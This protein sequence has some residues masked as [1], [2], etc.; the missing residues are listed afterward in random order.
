M[1]LG[2]STYLQIPLMAESDNQ[3]YLLHNDA[4]QA[5]DDSLNRIL[6]LDFS[7]SDV[8]LAESQ[9]TRYG[10]FRGVSHT[11]PRVLTIPTTVGVSPAITT[12]RFF[13]FQNAG[14]DS[15][16]LTHGSGNVVS[17]PAGTVTLVICDGTDVISVA[18]ASGFDMG[19][20]DE[21]SADF[22]SN[23]A[24][25]NFVGKN[26][27]ATLSGL[28][29]DI[30]VTMPEVEDGGVSVQT[31]T[32][33][34]N[35][36]GA[37]VT[38]VPNGDGVDITIPGATSGVDVEDEGVGTVTAAT[39]LDFIGA[40]VSVADVGGD[41]HVTISAPAAQ[42]EGVGVQSDP[43]FI[44]F[45]GAGVS[46]AVNGSGVD[47]TIPG[48]TG[49][50]IGVEN[51]GIS[52]VAGASVMNFIG[53][54]VTASDVGGEAHVTITS[55]AVRDEGSNAQ[56]DPT[57]INFVG[58]GVTA[59]ASGDGVNV[60]IPGASG[61][62]IPVDSSG[63]SAVASADRLNFIG[64]GVSVAANG[65][66]ADITI[67]GGGSALE[68]QSD[69]TQVVAA[70]DTINFTGTGVTV[71]NPSG[72]VT[73]VNISGGD[74]GGATPS[75]T[76]LDTIDFSTAPSSSQIVTDLGSYDE[77]ILICT[78]NTLAASQDILV[79]YSSDNGASFDT[80]VSNYVTRAGYAQY[81][82]LLNAKPGNELVSSGATGNRF[83]KARISNFG[84]A[85]PT[86]VDAE[87]TYSSGQSFVYSGHYKNA[88]K[89]N[90]LRI[91]TSGS[92]NITGGSLYVVGVRYASIKS[93]WKGARVALNSAV[94]LGAAVPKIID[95]NQVDRQ[96]D[97]WWNAATPSRLTVPTGVSRIRLHAN[98]ITTGGGGVE[99]SG[100][101]LRNGSSFVGMG[102]SQTDTP[103]TSLLNMSSDVIDVSP[104]DYFELEATTNNGADINFG[105][106]SWFSI[107]AVEGTW[108][109]AT[110]SYD[111]RTG[112]NTTPAASE[113]VDI[114]PIPRDVKFAADFSGS[115]GFVNTFP[116]A[117]FSLE[118]TDGTT[119]LGTV[120]IDTSG[121]FVFSTT[122][123]GVTTIPAGTV[124]RLI[125]PATPDATVSGVF[126]TLAGEI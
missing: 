17:V 124:L 33:K 12:N 26:V 36:V 99:L 93:P 78:D 112:F 67:S 122:S 38:A 40:N 89:H 57:F 18:S 56:S 87:T 34:F 81:T 63:V 23:P 76:L 61:T 96:A 102:Y 86:T 104:G 108:D 80:T 100:R 39:V 110:V 52:A 71:T 113:I 95:W 4:V 103:S 90:A 97:V 75:A 14:T 29:A 98:L 92:S 50:G 101:M 41:A 35:F 120:T 85:A 66:T 64:S 16:T 115:V 2:N 10:T 91:F 21:G 111:V 28:G 126:I 77:I 106:S 8:V 5:L 83:W 42:D 54:N 32:T 30:S 60:T 68:T 24:F 59:T 25:L 31:D 74:S 13:V 109:E 119:T 55:A 43:T 79:Q 121:A 125:A 19:V 82:I 27:A 37:G 105:D 65:N 62:A 116:S 47:V 46:A 84:I 58:A 44:N 49:A 53:Q 11:V 72:N 48:A 88:A 117:S 69:G 123:A 107:E 1:P 6:T 7:A 22:V 118:V 15:V 73:E 20:R 45:I 9:L 70:T 51:E 3:K 114:I 94:P